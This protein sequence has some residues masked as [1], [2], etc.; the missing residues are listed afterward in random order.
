MPPAQPPN[1][2]R[3]ERSLHLTSSAQRLQWRNCRHC[4]RNTPR[5]KH[6]HLFPLQGRHRS[7]PDVLG[8]RTS[9]FLPEVRRRIPVR[10]KGILLSHHVQTDQGTCHDCFEWDTGNEF[11]KL[12]EDHRPLLQKEEAE[13]TMRP[14]LHWNVPM[15]GCCAQ[16]HTDP[17]I[18]V[19]PNSFP[20]GFV[21]HLWHHA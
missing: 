19:R 1:L 7:K 8:S 14:I 11:D 10:P 12:T 13:L 4:V 6:P 9:T 2:L 15:R 5:M 21:P 17:R 20:Q 16:T 3:K 18:Q